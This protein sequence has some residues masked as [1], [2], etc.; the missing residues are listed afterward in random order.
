VPSAP[1]RAPTATRQAK[2]RHGGLSYRFLGPVPLYL[3]SRHHF[4]AAPSPE[5]YGNR[6]EQEFLKNIRPHQLPTRIRGWHRGCGGGGTQAISLDSVLTVNTPLTP[7][8]NDEVG[9]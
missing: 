9:F 8:E 6:Y 1:R 4:T 2:R 5:R 7:S 3:E